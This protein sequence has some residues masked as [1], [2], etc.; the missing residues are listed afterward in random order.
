MVK[1]G[2]RLVNATPFRPFRLQ[3]CQAVFLTM[4]RACFSIS[5]RERC[6]HGNDL[7]PE[8]D[9]AVF[10]GFLCYPSCEFLRHDDADFA[11]AAA[12]AAAGRRHRR[13]RASGSYSSSPWSCSSASLLW[14]F[15]FTPTR[16][17]V[18][19]FVQALVITTLRRCFIQTSSQKRKSRTNSPL[20]PP[21]S[22]NT[23]I[24]NSQA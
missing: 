17:R 19:A 23:K 9:S 22:R 4:L 7:L 3:G 16:L 1:V 5:P 13:R 15:A 20:P 10:C 6:N 11:A 2:V 12:A 8:A 14:S 18:A 21:L 24:L